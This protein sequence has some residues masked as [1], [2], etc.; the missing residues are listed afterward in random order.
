MSRLQA[1]PRVSPLIYSPETTQVRSRWDEQKRRLKYARI[2]HSL[3]PKGCYKGYADE[4]LRE[5]LPVRL[6]N[7]DEPKNTTLILSAEHEIKSCLRA[8]GSKQISLPDL[9]VNSSEH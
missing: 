7:L 4:Y 3:S 5:A 2:T 6:Q 1:S 9:L 8:R